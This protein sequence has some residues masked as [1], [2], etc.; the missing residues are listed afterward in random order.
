MTRSF[1]IPRNGVFANAPTCQAPTGW[2]CFILQPQFVESLDFVTVSCSSRAGLV[3]SEW[4]R[5]AEG[6]IECTF[7]IPANCIAALR[8]PGLPEKALGA[9][10]HTVSWRP[11]G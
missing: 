10:I 2:E 1:N 3:R 4:R 11:R 9:G 5:T 6:E 7:E 8:L